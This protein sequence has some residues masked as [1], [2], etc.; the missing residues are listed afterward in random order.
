L[1][2]GGV[3]S[4]LVTETLIPSIQQTP[5]KGSTGTVAGGVVTP[6]TAA[7]SRVTATTVAE[8][9][10]QA[11]NMKTVFDSKGGNS[12]KITVVETATG[13]SIFGLIKDT[14]TNQPIG[15]PAQDVIMVSTSNQAVL[16]AAAKNNQPA[17]LNANG[18]LVVNDGGLLGAAANGFRAN[19][20]GELVLLSTPTL[21]GN[22]TTDATGSFAGQAVIPAGFPVGNHTAV[23]ITSDLVTSMGVTVEPSTAVGLAYTGVNSSITDTWLGMAGLLAAFGLVM[24]LAGTRRKKL[25]NA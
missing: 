18:V 3:A 6:V 23:L 9:R 24:V 4:K 13:A 21:L 17:K 11:T 19:T 12:G 5:G 25:P 10:T 2:G 8:I 16:L 15:V 7:V 22:F 1:T 20:Q 14:V